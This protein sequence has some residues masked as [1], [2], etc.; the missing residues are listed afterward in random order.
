[1]KT[2]EFLKKMAEFGWTIERSKKHVLLLNRF[3]RAHRPLALP[4]DR[5]RQIDPEYAENT[6][7][8]AGLGWEKD[9]SLHPRRES[10]YYQDYL[11]QQAQGTAVGE[12]ALSG[13]LAPRVGTWY[14]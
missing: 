7:R 2:T 1:M 14:K 8:R 9:G 12:V 6:A 5:M 3:F 13:A 4:H 11:Q 10:P